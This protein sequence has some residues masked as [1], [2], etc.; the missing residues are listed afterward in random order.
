MAQLMLVN[1]RK[2]RRTV[3]KTRAKS[4]AKR[5]VA[6]RRNPI[7]AYATNPARRRR[8]RRT[9]PAKGIMTQV[10]DASM[11]AGGAVL[12]DL[13]SSRLPIP[14]DLKT[15]NMA[16][17]VRAGIALSLGFAVEKGLKQKAIGRK[18]AEG[19]L[20]VIA[21][22]FITKQF[23]SRIGLSAYEEM[24]AYTDMGGYDDLLLNT[25]LQGYGD[26]GLLGN[27]DLLGE[28]AFDNI[29]NMSGYEN[30]AMTYG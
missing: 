21:H 28:N 4:P 5:R 25:N 8:S 22:D 10:M 23:G 18:M 13:I 15:G 16:P 29:V 3:R 26:N 9:N 20:V 7:Q 24:A 6:R 19:S 27:G 17:V 2:R 12:T 30:A 1:P 11:M 14:A